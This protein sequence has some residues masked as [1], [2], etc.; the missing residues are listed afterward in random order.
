MSRYFIPG[1]ERKSM[2]LA[3]G[4]EATIATGERMT[5][6]VVELSPGAEIAPHDHPHE[7]IGAVLEGRVRFTIGDE[8]RVLEAGDFYRIPGG[9][10]H[11]AIA[12]DDGARVV[13]CFHPARDDYT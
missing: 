10:G 1:A 6:S 12:L 2:T 8:E 9:I 4:V 7:Q 11:S 5:A 3:P 13:D